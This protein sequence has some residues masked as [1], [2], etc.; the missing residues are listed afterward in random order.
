MDREMELTGTPS[1]LLKHVSVSAKEM[2][3]NHQLDLSPP[4]L[5]VGQSRLNLRMK[6]IM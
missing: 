3:V 2:P 5:E 1:E 4:P 6:V